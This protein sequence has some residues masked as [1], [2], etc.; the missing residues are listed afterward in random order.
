MQRHLGLAVLAVLAAS[1]VPALAQ[2]KAQPGP[3]P[4]CTA[5]FGTAGYPAL[6]RFVPGDIPAPARAAVRGVVVKSIT[7]RPGETVK[8]ALRLQAT[9]Q[10]SMM[11]QRGWV[12]L[13]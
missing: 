2:Q 6:T 1:A 3:D 9:S 12:A 5:A 4:L 7:W 13:F 8:V 10:I 11:R